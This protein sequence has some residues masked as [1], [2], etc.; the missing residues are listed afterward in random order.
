MIKGNQREVN[1]NFGKKIGLAEVE[2][3]AINPTFD[4]FDT[5][6]GIELKEDSKA[7]VYKGESRDGNQ[8][9]RI[10]FWVQTVEDQ[11][12]FKVSYFLEDSVRMNKDG[13]KTQYINNIGICSWAEEEE[14]LPSWFAK[15]EYREAK[16]GEED[17][18]IFIRTWLGKLD[19]RSED[20]EIDLD[21]KKLMKGDVSVLREQIDG[22]FSTSFVVMATVV[23]KE[24]DDEMKEYQNIYSRQF[25]PAYALRYFNTVDYSDPDVL[26]KINKKQNKDLKIH[27]RFVKNVTGEYG[28]R[29]IYALK[30]LEEFVSEDHIVASDATMGGSADE[31]DLY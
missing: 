8:Y 26:A 7:A 15:R 30:P 27:E 13:D 11:Q 10:D 25:L 1:E 4:E 28:C 24:V 23:V 2:V 18:Y 29:D 22:D 19:Y 16:K 20:T 12:K 17:F 5:V 9:T 21:W 6:L 31:E 3:I 14:G